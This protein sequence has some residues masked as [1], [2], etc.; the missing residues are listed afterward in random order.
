MKRLPVLA[1]CLL[2]PILASCAGV[3]PEP[4][5]T[6]TPAPMPSATQDIV[7]FSVSTPEP[8]PSETPAPSPV[9]EEES[10]LVAPEQPNLLNETEE[11]QLVSISRSI[12]LYPEPS[13]NSEYV[14]LSN[15][16]TLSAVS[17]L[18]VLE[19][20]ESP[21]GRQFYHVRAAFSGEEGYV[22][23]SATRPSKLASSGVT[24]FAMTLPSGTSILAE[25][26]LKG[27]VLAVEYSQAVRILGEY[28]DYYYVVSERGNSGFVNPELLQLIDLDELNAHLAMA[29]IP[30]IAAT[31]NDPLETASA[32]N[33][34]KMLRAG[35]NS[36]AV[37][38]WDTAQ[39]H[40]SS[41]NRLKKA[42]V[43]M[44]SNAVG[45]GQTPI[46]RDGIRYQPC[47]DVP[48]LTEG[49][50]LQEKLD[51]NIHG[52]IYTSSPLILVAADF[53]SLGSSKSVSETVTFDP[54]ANV[55]GYSLEN[56]SLPLEGKS[57]DTL[58]DI[59][60][61]RP[62]RYRFTLKAAT[63]A[64]PE[65]V[66]LLS[67]E[68]KIVDTDRI[69]LTQNKFDDN[70]YDALEFF[71]GDTDK[72]IFHYSLKDTRDI[73]T[74]ND[75]RNTYIVE[76]SLG[77]VH[78][79][80][81]PYFETAYHYL[82][83]TYIRVDIQ[84]P[85]SGKITKGL[86][87]SLDKLI[88]KD[89]T[90]VPRFQSNLAYVSHH[91]LGTAIDVNDNMYP[92]FNILT[93]HDLIGSEVRNHLVYNGI[94][95]TSEGLSYYHFTYDGS[96]SARYFKIPKTILNYLLYELAFFRAGFEWGYYYETACDGMHFM[97]TENDVN[98]HMHS[99]IG[100]RKVFEYIEPEWTYVPPS[101]PAPEG[102]P[103]PAPEG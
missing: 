91:T 81:V 25:P 35:E 2:L 19:E 85:R 76:S 65:P 8:T 87:M 90:Y 24:G 77:R 50:E 30:A 3:A 52:S 53:T 67:V 99:D 100:L 33:A 47:L 20:V 6:A 62:G 46:G 79:D 86:V 92:N 78:Q 73:A 16:K 55:R 97:L 60:T 12:K 14:V 68:C 29:V 93:N 15:E 13:L 18:I 1:I 4:N 42:A 74:E 10:A 27:A 95:T 37:L 43:A 96:Y 98:R 63:A 101:T 80:A 94:Q 51:Y 7:V 11:L 31:M 56:E 64:Q 36:A 66:T 38:N 45:T 40:A 103:T 83:N 26:E 72:F 23:P 54:E 89:T 69:I 22:L 21:E 34:A 5:P 44:L 59:R 17:D 41:L 57:L 39:A 58:F 48:P 49:E 61:L 32:A 28:K 71:G 102:E 84:S 75:W 70:Y 82:T 9:A 88:D